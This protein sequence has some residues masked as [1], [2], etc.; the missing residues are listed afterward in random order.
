M[1]IK[2][3]WL[4]VSDGASIYLKQWLPENEAI[5]VLQIAHGMVE[6]IERYHD[7]ASYC[8]SL[9]FV[10]IG[11]DHRGHGKT[12]DTGI[13]GY[14]TEKNGFRRVVTDLYE[15]MQF[16]KDAFPHLPYYCLGHSMGSFLMR[17]FIQH[18]STEID[19]VILTGTGHYSRIVTAIGKR[20]ASLLP[21]TKPSPL[22]NNLVL[23]SSMKRDKHYKH[24][25]LTRDKTL[26]DA[27]EVDPY[28]G[29]IP[30]ARFFYDLLEGIYQTRDQNL[31]QHIRKNLPLLLISG[32]Q[33]P[34][35]QY[36][37][38]VWKTADLFQKSGLTNILVQVYEGGR[39]ELLNDT[40]RKEVF[41]F[42]GRWL[43]HSKK[44]N[45]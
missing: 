45:N 40:C 43:K 8:T 7:F 2:Q 38:G 28:T 4:D 25:W 1:H 37:N 11:C 20:V 12:G 18:Y 41:E 10:V 9:G 44:D 16:G 42:I 39:H 24:E 29:F 3:H 33:D 35:G 17:N 27:Y 26:A 30:T 5:G 14:F 22:M 36:G 13:Q 31:N 34:I 21:A 6:H 19:G 23:G 15:I 32:D